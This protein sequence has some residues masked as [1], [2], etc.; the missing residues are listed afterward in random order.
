MEGHR[1]HDSICIELPTGTGKTIVFTRY[2]AQQK[3][4]RS[5]VVCPQLPLIRQAAAK[6]RD[7]TGTAPA[8][9][10]AS[11]WSDE[12]MEELRNPFVVAS[13]QTLTK[14]RS[15]GEPRYK[16]FRGVGLVIVDECHYACTRPYIEM[17]DWFV[18]RGA[19]VLGVSATL[20][21]HDGKALGAV[22]QKC[23]RQYPL[24]QAVE[25]GWLV[26]PRVTCKQIKSLDLTNVETG[27]TVAGRDWN[28][29]QLDEELT[30]PAVVYEIAEAIAAETKGKRT[31][32]YCASVNE[33]QALAELLIDSYGIAAA[34][35]CSDNRRVAK[36][37]WRSIMD[38]FTTGELTHVCNVGQ[39]T[40]G[41]DLP[42]LEAIVMARPT[43][44]TTLYTQI[45]GRGT[46][47]LPGVVD[48][49]ESTPASRCAAIAKSRK[50]SFHVVDLV[51]NSLSHKVV[52]VVDVLG[53]DMPEEVRKRA[54]A[55]MLEA[56][57]PVDVGE[58]SL[59]AQWEEEV[60]EHARLREQRARMKAK[61]TFEDFDVD[62][63]AGRRV[64]TRTTK[65]GEPATLKQIKFLR[66]KLGRSAQVSDIT[67]A[68]ASRMIGRI[69]A[70]G[71][72]AWY[73]RP[74]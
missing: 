59:A 63:F 57:E 43:Q 36:A 40:T 11:L 51:D 12:H 7:E 42:A 67:K 71:S 20:Q 31:A 70:G 33:A 52:T 41:W 54:K 15:D 16:R 61:A 29:K 49:P 21:R 17:L 24:R 39:L 62:V 13:K 32:I 46:R 48:F 23:V 18:A 2:A 50:P 37:D 35:I 68:T 47:P 53:G 26:K 60:E 44:S 19:K 56:D 14:S 38:R 8:I 72:S 27:M 3:F 65:Q 25:D 1:N 6:I 5:I 28:Q 9:E 74:K 73:R 30:N 69:K 22:F 34:W 10:Q 66:W 4:G 45:M 64:Q 58:T 55:A